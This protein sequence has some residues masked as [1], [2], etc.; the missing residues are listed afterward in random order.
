MSTIDLFGDR[1]RARFRTVGALRAAAFRLC[2]AT[3]GLRCEDLAVELHESI[4]AH[5]PGERGERL[6][7][8]ARKRA[9]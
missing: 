1:P 2:E 9:A 8:I 6:S 3:R 5:F 7:A 4:C